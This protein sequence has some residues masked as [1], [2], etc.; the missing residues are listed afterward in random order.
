VLPLIIRIINN[1]PQRVSARPMKSAAAGVMLAVLMA[2]RLA[3]LSL[4][5]SLALTGCV[6]VETSS[7]AG[8]PVMKKDVKAGGLDED[9]VK[10][11][12]SADTSFDSRIDKLAAPGWATLLK[13]SKPWVAVVSNETPKKIVAFTT[14]FRM[15]DKEGHTVTN[16]S[17]SVAP[18]AI[19]NPGVNFGRKSERGIL[20]GG[21]RL[22][23]LGF[24]IPEFAQKDQKRSGWVI[25]E[26]RKFIEYS[27]AEYVGA[28]SV[29]VGL[30]AVIF[31]DGLLI[32]PDTAGLAAHFDSLVQARQ[33]LYG[34]I[35]RRIGQGDSIE[36]SFQSGMKEKASRPSPSAWPFASGE[37]ASSEA[38]N[39]ASGL[40]IEY[41]DSKIREVLKRALLPA[42]FVIY[43]K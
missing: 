16:S 30:D 1:R 37:L 19:G 2:N 22:T 17:F 27:T 24:A 20:P 3:K 32:G 21:Q 12:S 26:T 36:A 15:T 28:K 18:D 23:G 33:D 25:D 39:A 43:K 31:E 38:M 4:L 35:L 10:V 34:A 41:G 7:M 11:I 14:M 6:K 40:R 29:H 42:P 13:K 8:P 9:G 5:A